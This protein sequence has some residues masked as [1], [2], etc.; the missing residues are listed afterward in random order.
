MEGDEYIHFLHCSDN[1]KDAYLPQTYQIVHF[2]Y[3][4]FI[5]RKLYLD[6][7][8]LKI[9]IQMSSCSS[10]GEIFYQNLV[11]RV[12]NMGEF[13]Q[14]SR[15]NLLSPQMCPPSGRVSGKCQTL[16]SGPCWILRA[17]LPWKTASRFVSTKG[18]QGPRAWAEGLREEDC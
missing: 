5:L 4:Q 6:K 13:S 2:K 3:M 1:F 7:V 10:R 12:E 11:N 14:V 9:N 15:T 16:G 18:R 8:V 17:D